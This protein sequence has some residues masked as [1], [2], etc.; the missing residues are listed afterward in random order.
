MNRTTFF[1]RFLLMMTYP[2]IVLWSVQAFMGHRNHTDKIFLIPANFLFNPETHDFLYH[3]A[4]L[5]QTLA[6]FYTGTTHMTTDTM[7]TGL[8]FHA[9]L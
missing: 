5:Y 4:W 6:I 7:A 9:G 1:H 3:C 2:T 8:V